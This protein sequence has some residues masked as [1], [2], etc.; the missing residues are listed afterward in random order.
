[1]AWSMKDDK[2]MPDIETAR[3][4]LRPFTPRDADAYYLAVMCDPDV[5]RYLPG[6]QPLP[7]ERAELIMGRFQDHWDQHGFGGWA[8]IHRAD[9]LLIGQ[10]GLQYIPGMTEVEVFYALAKAFWGQGLAP[11]AAHAAL[12]YGF[13]TL[14]LDR[15]V[16]IFMPGN[17][18]SERVMIKIGM[19]Y[20]G[21][22]HVYETDLPF[23]AITRAEFRPGDA[24]YLL[25][26]Q[27]E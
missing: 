12:R 27:S 18:A 8:V 1:L 10:C 21:I 16:A 23:Y 9:D 5:R 26:N 19:T 13:E 20:Q 24:P 11:E 14:H 4:R 7:R 2:P 3:L 6:G 15:I 22:K 17:Q 25:H